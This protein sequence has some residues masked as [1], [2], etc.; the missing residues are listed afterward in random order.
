MHGT[1]RSSCLPA[2]L[3]AS[4]DMTPGSSRATASWLHTLHAYLF[5]Y[6]HVSISNC[7]RCSACKRGHASPCISVLMS[8][9]H[10]VISAFVCSVVC[11]LP[12]HGG[13]EHELQLRPT[14]SPWYE[15]F[16]HTPYIDISPD[17]LLC[18]VP[19][20]SPDGTCAYG[21]THSLLTHC[22]SEILINTQPAKGLL[23]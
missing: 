6:L 4:H 3:H 23:R 5:L 17:G 10:R 7:F 22:L 9:Q 13:T 21:L 2:S 1:A 18:I 19:D 12:Q 20:I 8:S 11:T 14:T 16:L 15:C